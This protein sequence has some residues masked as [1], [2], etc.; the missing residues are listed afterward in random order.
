MSRVVEGSRRVEDCVG[1]GVRI[2][3]V[4]LSARD[5]L[6]ASRQSVG[7]E[8]PWCAKKLGGRWGTVRELTG[9]WA[10]L[11]ER[12]QS[13]VDDLGHLHAEDVT[14]ARN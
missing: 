7:T 6:V 5:P 3:N 12:E 8:E 4:E 2:G 1:G 13:L 14:G 11:E 10:G 9:S